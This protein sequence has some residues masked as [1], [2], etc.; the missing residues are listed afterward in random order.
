MALLAARTKVAKRLQA[1]NPKL[2]E[3]EIVSRMV[4]YS[5]DQAHSSVERAGL[6]SGVRMKKIQSDENFVA[7]GEALKRAL[8]ADKAE[9]LL[10]VF[11]CATLGTTSSCS[12]DNLMELGPICNAENIWLHVDAAYAGSAFICPEFRYLMK[13]VEF[14]DSFN[15]NPHKWLL[16]NFDCSAFWVKKR[17]DLIGAFKLDPV[18]LQYDQQAS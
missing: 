11:V 9:G 7:H 15:F 18:Y 1:E 4:A 13:G 16:V 14:A 10:P 12:F 17:S 5:S 8:E 2:S 6:I 3:A